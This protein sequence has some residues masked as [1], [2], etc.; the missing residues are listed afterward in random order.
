MVIKNRLRWGPSPSVSGMQAF[1]QSQYLSCTQI[2]ISILDGVVINLH[3]LFPKFYV[4]PFISVKPCY[5][6]LPSITLSKHFFKPYESYAPL[7]P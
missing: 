1:S 6:E 2:A 3:S 4:Y 5:S 7:L